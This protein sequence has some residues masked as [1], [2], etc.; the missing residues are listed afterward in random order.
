MKL[1]G[2]SRAKLGVGGLHGHPVLHIQEVMSVRQ[3][4]T[5]LVTSGIVGL[6]V[7]IFFFFVGGWAARQRVSE[8]SLSHS[9]FIQF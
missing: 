9:V 1:L 4:K 7:F 2:L 5:S 3:R 8:C 6:C